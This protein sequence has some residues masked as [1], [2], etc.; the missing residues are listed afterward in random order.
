[1]RFL[2]GS[3]KGAV[4]L[5]LI[6]ITTVIFFFNAILIDF[7]RIMAAERQTN[8]AVKAGIRSVLSAYDTELQR[9]GLYAIGISEEDAKKVFNHVVH[10]N[11]SS[12]L[13]P[14]FF[15]LIDTQLNEE[16]VNLQFKHQLS[17]QEIMEQQ[18]LEEMKYKAPAEVLLEVVD[19]LSPIE[20]KMKNA[21]EEVKESKQ[22]INKYEEFKQT[23]QKIDTDMNELIELQNDIQPVRNIAH[24][25]E[26]SVDQDVDQDQNENQEAES[27]MNKE[28]YLK[29]INKAV[30]DATRITS[31][32]ET[33]EENILVAIAISKSLKEYKTNTTTVNGDTDC[34]IPNNKEHDLEFKELE[35][36]DFTSYIDVKESLQ[37][38]R[39]DLKSNSTSSENIADQVNVIIVNHDV[40]FDHVLVQNNRVNKLVQKI[41]GIENQVKIIEKCFNKQRAETGQELDATMQE[42]EG[43]IQDDDY[44]ALKRFYEKY[45]TTQL[46]RGFS[47]D[48]GNEATE[49]GEEAIS[50]MDVVFGK[51]SGM[52]VNLRDEAYI[53]EFALSKFNYLTFQ[54]GKAFD[55]VTLVEHRLKQQENEYILYGMHAPKVNTASALAEIFTIRLAIRTVEGFEKYKYLGVPKL[56]AISAITHGIIKANQDLI[57][58]KAGHEVVLTKYTPNIKLNYLNYIRLFLLIHSDK[59]NKISRIQ[60]LIELNTSKNLAEKH[61]YIRASASTSIRLWFIPGVMKVLD[62]VNVLDGDVV[63]NRYQIIKVAAMSY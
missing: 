55:P 1:L 53:N 18:I 2:I 39:T 15:K 10:Q 6:I 33:L 36:L 62:N 38:L 9:Y 23:I 48:I 61:T 30:G 13:S 54:E 7:A 42:L 27:T 45:K 37:A 20:Q 24:L 50:L 56:I 19:K 47:K 43:T 58:L 35:T 59:S 17:D 46:H 11:L 31:L 34:G 25:Y 14:D 41:N 22:E 57:A 44:K 32:E 52:M 4:S 51:V 63:G 40:Y 28:R 60:S 26:L 29:I 49:L 5:Y 3:E 16:T 21:S 12:D 8:N